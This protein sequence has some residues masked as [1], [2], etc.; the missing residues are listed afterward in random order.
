M[1]FIRSSNCPLYLVPAT[2]AAKSKEIVKDPVKQQ[3][4]ADALNKPK[5]VNK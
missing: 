5:A 1:A 3:A 2:S 4:L